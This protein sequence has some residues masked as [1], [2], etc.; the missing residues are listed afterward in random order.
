MQSLDQ[1]NPP[2]TSTVLEFVG[3]GSISVLRLRDLA[4]AEMGLAGSLVVNAAALA[5]VSASSLTGIPLCPGIY[6][7]V[8]GPGRALRR[9]RR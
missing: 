5:A 9:D 7:H 1:E 2:Y 8:V 3:G 4:E 6:R